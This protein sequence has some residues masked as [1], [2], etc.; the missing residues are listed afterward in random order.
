MSSSLGCLGKG[1]LEV[2]KLE[3]IYIERHLELLLHHGLYHQ[4]QHHPNSSASLT[5]HVFSKEKLECRE[6][7]PEEWEHQYEV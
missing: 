5:S 3:T 6:R 1:L 4:E 7:V 2:V